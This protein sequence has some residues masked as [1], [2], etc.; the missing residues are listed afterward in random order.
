MCWWLVTK[1]KYG[2][3]ESDT[4]SDI[5]KLRHSSFL[6][7]AE[8]LYSSLANQTYRHIQTDCVT[9]YSQT[10]KQT[11]VHTHTDRQTEIFRQTKTMTDRP[12]NCP[13]RQHGNWSPD[14]HPLTQSNC[15]QYRYNQN[16]TWQHT[17]RHS[18]IQTD[19]QPPQHTLIDLL[20]TL[21]FL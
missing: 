9:S 20:Q 10:E 5:E 11:Y 18:Y 15:L 14:Q 13:A 6:H 2:V 7:A 12:A 17:D 21:S 3:K 4:W 16:I 1:V 8:C 19:K